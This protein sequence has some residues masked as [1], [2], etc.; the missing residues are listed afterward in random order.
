MLPQPTIKRIEDKL[1]DTLEKAQQIYG[2]AF[3]V[4]E[5]H[6]RQMGRTAGRAWYCGE[7]GKIEIN[8]D[9]C[10]NGHLDEMVNQTLPH[11]IAHILANVIYKVRGHGREWKSVMVN[12]GLEP[13]RCHNY[14]LEGVKTR[15]RRRN[16]ATYC[17]C[18]RHDVT[19]T[20][21]NR[22]ARGYRYWCNTCKQNLRLTE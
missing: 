1:L 4:P 3:K 12:L 17:G 18:G 5:L 14:S 20:I 19:A 22:M 6:F 10:L 16:H 8:P 15:V 21:H 2:R 11:E 9:F 7:E 13:R